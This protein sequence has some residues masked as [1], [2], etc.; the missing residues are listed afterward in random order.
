MGCQC[1]CERAQETLYS[2]VTGSLDCGEEY[3]YD[4]LYK[5][6]VVGDSNSGKTNLVGRFVEAFIPEHKPTIGVD[7]VSEPYN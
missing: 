3:S 7:R 1:S 5:L 4:H 2:R 6:V